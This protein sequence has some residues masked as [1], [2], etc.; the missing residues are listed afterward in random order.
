MVM[1]ADMLNG[2]NTEMTMPHSSMMHQTQR[3]MPPPPMYPEPQVTS[4]NPSFS[5]H[6]PLNSSRLSG[7]VDSMNLKGTDM[8]E[9][10]TLKDP[11]RL[12]GVHVR[13]SDG[14]SGVLMKCDPNGM[15][16][17]LLD[18]QRRVQLPTANLNPVMAFSADQEVV[19]IDD[20][21]SPQRAVMVKVDG[22]DLVVK[23]DGVARL[24]KTAVVVDAKIYSENN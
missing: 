19:V 21:D 9:S 22:E 7:S 6:P 10:S 18:D 3:T 2:D 20:P 13:T 17:V 23:I 16:E 15:N 5:Q 8:K 11:W 14:R 1:L 24:V 12:V 4:W